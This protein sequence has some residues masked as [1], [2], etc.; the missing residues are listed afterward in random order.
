MSSNGRGKPP[1]VA[2]RRYRK[3]GTTAAKKAKPRAKPAQ[4][5]RKPASRRGPLG[6]IAA[7]FGRIVKGILALIWRL[8]WRATAVV[9]LLI[10]LGVLYYAMQLPPSSE[11]IDGRARGSVTL[12]DRDGTPFAWRGESPSTC[13]MPSSRRRTS[14]STGT[15]A[16]IRAASRAR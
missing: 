12:L 6:R 14:A 5:R 4:S 7:F 15:R 1:L 16:S 10:G 3:R 2:D 13:T 8:T 9:T 11:L